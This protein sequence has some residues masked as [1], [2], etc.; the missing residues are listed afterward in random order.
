MAPQTSLFGKI[1][2]QNRPAIF[3]SCPNL[4]PLYFLPYIS[5]IE[6]LRFQRR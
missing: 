6:Y 5:V 4:R 2:S 3:M 1:S